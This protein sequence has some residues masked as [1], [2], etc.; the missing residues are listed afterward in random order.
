MKR[1]MDRVGDD[2]EGMAEWRDEVCK[3]K[4]FGVLIVRD[5]HGNVGVLKAYSGQINGRADWNG[6]VPAVF[7]YLQPDGY[8]VKHEQEITAVNRQL[9]EK[10]RSIELRM[11]AARLA[12]AEQE[13][14][15]RIASYKEFMAAEK[16]S[17]RERREQGCADDVLIAES[18][19]QKA[20]LKRIKQRAEAELLPMRNAIEERHKEMAQ[21]RMM[22]K[23]M[24]DNLQTWLFDQFVMLNANGEKMTLTEVFSSTPQRIPPSGAGEC[25]AP[26]L[27]QYAYLHGYTPLELAEFWWGDSPKGEIRRHKETYPAC[28]GKCKPILDFMLQGVEVEPNPLESSNHELEQ[29]LV[30]QLRVIHHDEYVVVVD[31]P[32]GMLSVP[33]RTGAVSVQEI[34]GKM[35]KCDV[36]AVHRLDMQTSGVLVLAKDKDVCKQLQSEF[37]RHNTGKTYVAVVERNGRKCRV[38]EKGTISLPLSPDYMHRP[39]QMVDYV[40][41]KDATTDYEVEAV[42]EET[43]RLRLHP[44]QGRTHQLRVHCAHKDGLSM[45]IVGDSLYGHPAERMLLH[46]ERLVLNNPLTGYTYV[47]E[48]PCSF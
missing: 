6:W 22:R 23:Q 31:K 41:G 38:G 25:C 7:D 48:S 14:A 18:Q 39:C 30:R 45:P 20:E 46:A 34:L 40:S 9:E 43:V 17:R 24:S 28:Q 26:K 29:Q 13:A 8:F 2:I 27:L 3:G 10:E 1:V 21:L 16:L 12:K 44:R 19:F 5:Q 4:M 11:M 37:A 32:S 36:Y 15:E 35:L 42:E 47:F 33:G